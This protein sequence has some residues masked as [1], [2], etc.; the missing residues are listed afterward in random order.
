[1]R[2]ILE[3]KIEEFTSQFEEGAKRQIMLE[4]AVQA[5]KLALEELP[6]PPPAAVDDKDREG[7]E[8]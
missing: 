8:L 5:L 6:P 2:E 3:K 1:M 4:G 7:K